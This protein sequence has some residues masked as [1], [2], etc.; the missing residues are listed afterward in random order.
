MLRDSLEV[1]LEGG[2]GQMQHRKVAQPHGFRAKKRDRAAHQ[3]DGLDR[4]TLG[5]DTLQA[6]ETQPNDYLVI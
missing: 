6:A 5:A 2:V 4:R 3:L 1:L